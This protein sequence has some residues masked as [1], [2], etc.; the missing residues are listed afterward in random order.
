M[1]ETIYGVFAEQM[2]SRPDAVA[3]ED[4]RR[5][6]TFAE[7]DALAGSVQRML[8]DGARRVD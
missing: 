7:L 3:V 4:E 6:V 8:P 1:S 5:S 2:S